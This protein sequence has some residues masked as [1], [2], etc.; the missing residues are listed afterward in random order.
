MIRTAFVIPWFGRD[1]VGGAEQHIFQVTTRLAARGHHVE[2]LTT[3]G[4]SFQDDWQRDHFPE[5]TSEESGVLLRRF[6]L[7]PRDRAAFD[8]ANRQLIALNERPKAAGVSP[9]PDAVARAFVDENVHS[10]RLRDYIESERD[11]YRSI[12][13]SPYLYGPT[14][15]GVECAGDRACLQ[16]LLHDETYAYLPVVESVFHRARRVFFISEGEAT[17]AARLFGPAM[18]RKGRVLGGGGGD[19]A[20]GESRSGALPPGIAAGEFLLYLGRRDRTKNT[21]LLVRAFRQYRASNAAARLQLVLAGPGEVPW[22]EGQRDGIVD[23]G[24]VPEPAKAALLAQCRVLVQPSQNESYSRTMMEA[25]LCSRPVMVHADCLATS[26]AVGSSGGGWTADSEKAWA[27]VFA[28]V[29]AL[30]DAAL[31][32]RGERGKAYAREHADWEKVIDRYEEALELRPRGRARPELRRRSRGAIHQLTAGLDHGDAISNQILFIAEVLRDLGY[33]SG[34]FAEHVGRG[35][36]DFASTFAPAALVPGEGIIYHHG[37]GSPL[38]AHAVRHAGP[39]ALIYHNITPAHFFEPWEPSFAKLL[40]NG[41]KDLRGMAA[42]FPISAGVSAYNA[43]ELRETG[44]RDPLVVPIFIDPMRWAQPADPE[45]MRILQDGRTNLL[46]VGRV[47]PNKCQHHLVQ[48]FHEYLR[49]DPGARLI[50]AG[51]WPDGHPYARFVRDEAERL[52]V[53]AQVWLTS[54][55]TDAQLQACYRTAHLFWSMSEHEG[56]CVPVIEAMWFDVPVLAYASSALPETLGRAG[57]L[58]TEKRWP[59]LAALAHMLVED[60]ALRRKVIAAQRARRTVFLPEAILPA[61]LDLIARLD[62][63]GESTHSGHDQPGSADTSSQ[64]PSRMRGQR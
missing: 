29:E 34:I 35:M 46:F 20:A 62:A 52:G 24:L 36:A 6:P 64:Y 7:R 47:S 4:R 37:I 12:V 15:L 16:P 44:F 63:Q 39:K 32:G 31:A 58:F 43:A 45:W 13:F 18:W 40:A 22:G 41:R 14:L 28:R 53:A 49:H 25:W 5:G 23:L 54:R 1:L 61:L 8:E 57:I 50:L 11:R 56:F 26:L 3:C 48:A 17:L 30:D 2:V 10:P 19:L 21:D 33:R 27:D 9:V 59:E 51:V 55:I 42:A 60:R 38:A